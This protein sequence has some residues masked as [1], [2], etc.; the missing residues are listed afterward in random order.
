MSENEKKEGSLLQKAPL[1]LFA[2]A[3]MKT[4]SRAPSRKPFEQKGR[5]R[6][7]KTGVLGS[8]QAFDRVA[9][10]GAAKFTADRRKTHT[11]RDFAQIFEASRGT[12]LIYAFAHVVGIM[13]LCTSVK[14]GREHPCLF[15]SLKP[16]IRRTKRLRRS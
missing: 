5:E 3:R 9:A 15:S 8:M 10:R 13:H 6:Y 12:A 11:Y 14:K 1:F 2:R 7:E 16:S 4:N